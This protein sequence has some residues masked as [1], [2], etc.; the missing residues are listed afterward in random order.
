MNVYTGYSV[1][2]IGKGKQ[3]TAYRFSR[4]HFLLSF[5]G[6]AVVQ[7]DCI[8]N[9]MDDHLPT[10]VFQHWIHSWEED[11]EDIQVYRP[12][13]Y[14]FPP[15]RGRDGFELKANGEFILSGPG[16]TDRPQ[17]ITGTWILQSNHQI[18]VQVP[19]WGD[20]GRLM[21]LVFCNDEVLRVRW[22]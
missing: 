19:V 11:M 17:S 2:V 5:V 20:H 7:L 6:L 4:R 18:R 15:S 14:Q 9:P 21:E 12:S 8:K 10:T 22:L 1:K 16:P 13:S 3:M